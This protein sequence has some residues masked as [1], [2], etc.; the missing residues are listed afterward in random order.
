MAPIRAVSFDAGQT[1][2]HPEPSV[3]SVYRESFARHGLVVSADDVRRAVH[4]TWSDVNAR[5]AAGAPDRWRGEDGQRRSR[6]PREP[7]SADAPDTSSVGLPQAEHGFWRRF[8]AHI[9]AGCGGGETPEALLAELVAYF[10][11]E[12]HWAVYP[13][14]RAVIGELKARGLTLLV[15]SNWDSSLPAL[16]H[17]L[18]L[19]PLFDF[20]VVSAVVGHSKPSGRIFEEALRLVE[21]PAPAVLHVGDSLKDD[22]DG[23]RAA[24]LAAL[25]LDRHGRAPEGVEAI[26]S[27]TE[28]PERIASLAES[29]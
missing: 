18:E 2:V 17:R 15:I 3:E 19:A 7:T 20:V 9:Y 22:Y 13:D 6:A 8:V 23:A 29:A 26:R 16:L 27:L 10:A 12:S 24:G 5:A 21:L 28:I 14:A 4:A 1:L 25:L 11:D